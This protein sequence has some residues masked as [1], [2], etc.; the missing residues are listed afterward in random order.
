[1]NMFT[2]SKVPW[3]LL[4]ILNQHTIS[5]SKSVGFS[6][7]FC[8]CLI[9]VIV[10]SSFCAPFLDFVSFVV[11]FRNFLAF[12]LRPFFQDIDL[13][14]HLEER[15]HRSSPSGLDNALD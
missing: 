12:F 1:M 3:P 14:Q 8:L 4:I 2:N 5:G 13:S 10:D 9:F 7:P 11:F 15:P 6:P